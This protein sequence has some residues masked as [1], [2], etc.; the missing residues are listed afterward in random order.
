[1]HPLCNALPVRMCQCG[2]RAVLWS[3][4][5][6]LMR[7]LVTERRRI[8]V[9]LFPSVSLWNDLADPVLDNHGQT[10]L[11]AWQMLFH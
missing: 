6:I 9:F 3:H 1:M 8:A 10:V 4:I 2:L 11:R 5:G 7:L